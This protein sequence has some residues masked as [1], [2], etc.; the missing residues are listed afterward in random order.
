MENDNELNL[1]LDDLDQI[2]VNE[3][4]KLQVKDRFAK[5]SEKMT[6]TAREKEEAE[7][8]LKVETEA[9][10]K[11]EKERDF[12]RDFSQVSSKYPKATEYQDQ[13]LEKVNSGYTAEDAALAILAKEGK[14]QMESP[15]PDN[16]TGGS[17]S[18]VINETGNKQI[19][20]MSTDEK[21][22]ALFQMEKEG[23]NLLK[24]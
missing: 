9:K 6:L 1:N 2:Q 19:E 8:K 15:R 24:L 10:S 11:V 5:L 22:N 3:E 12:F 14:L 7:T 20:E 17:A 23:I 4:K 13:I 21:R 16:I 18:T